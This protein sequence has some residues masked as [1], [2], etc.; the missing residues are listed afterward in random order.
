[1]F[2]SYPASV[3]ARLGTLTREYKVLRGARTLSKPWLPAILTGAQPILSPEFRT[4]A[5]LDRQG[6]VGIGKTR[7]QT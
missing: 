3:Q 7:A 1:M 4:F 6:A 2:G 5:E